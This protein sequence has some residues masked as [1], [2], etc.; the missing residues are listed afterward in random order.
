MPLARDKPYLFVDG[1]KED[2]QG[3]AVFTPEW[4]QQEL[5]EGEQ[6]RSTTHQQHHHLL[7]SHAVSVEHIQQPTETGMLLCTRQ[8]RTSVS[9]Y[10]VSSSAAHSVDRML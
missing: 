6:Q 9:W 7:D 3:A 2:V 4:N 8:K 10:R 1:K 5:V